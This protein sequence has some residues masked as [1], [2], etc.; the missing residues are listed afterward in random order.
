[1]LSLGMIS[2]TVKEAGALQIGSI[3]F[4]IHHTPEGLFI[5]FLLHLISKMTR[6]NSIQIHNFYLATDNIM[7]TEQLAIK[8]LISSEKNLCIE[9]FFMSI[10]ILNLNIYIKF[11]TIKSV[12]T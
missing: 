4:C 1:M 2:Q 3:M 7:L 5:L 8:L 9:L 10:R 6:S 11:T 12:M